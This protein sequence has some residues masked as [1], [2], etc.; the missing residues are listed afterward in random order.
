M[1]QGVVIKTR[2]VFIT[3]IFMTY[4]IMT[5]QRIGAKDHCWLQW[6]YHRC[7]ASRAMTAT[8]TRCIRLL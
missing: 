8:H 5:S 7:R 2:K 4:Y 6:S 1:Q 3:T